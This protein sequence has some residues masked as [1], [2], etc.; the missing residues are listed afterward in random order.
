M[1]IVGFGGANCQMAAFA[2]SELLPN[3]WRHYGVVLADLT[4]LMA[5][6]MGPVTARYGMATDTWRWNFYPTAILQAFSAAG[7]Y[8][9]YFPPKH[10]NGLPYAQVFKEM[11]YVG[12]LL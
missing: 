2:L 10:P 6:T 9:F 3:K 5:V 8:F 11:D 12:E 1:T 4:T 7:L